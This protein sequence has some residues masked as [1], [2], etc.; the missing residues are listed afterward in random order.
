MPTQSQDTHP[1]AGL[2]QNISSVRNLNTLT[3]VLLGK[4]DRMQPGMRWT[5]VVNL[6]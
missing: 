1:E 3:Y 2:V 6:G 4:L 5:S